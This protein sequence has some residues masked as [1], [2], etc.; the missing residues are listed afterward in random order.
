LVF[1]N[2]GTNLI[3]S[4]GGC[5]I[6]TGPNIGYTGPAVPGAPTFTPYHFIGSIG[7]VP[8]VPSCTSPPRI[9]TVT[10]NQ[11]ISITTQPVNASACT[12]KV[13]SF[14]V[15]AAGTSPSYQ[16]QVST[17]AGNTFTNVSNGGV[18]AGATSATLTITAP[19]VSMSGYLY[20]CMV[21]GASPCASVPSAQRLLTVNPLPT[22]TI[23]ASPY[24]K[25][26]PGLKTS[27]FSTVTPA[28]ASYTWL[29]NGGTVAGGNA[30]SLIVDVDGLGTYT[31]RVTDINGCTN[32]S[33]AVTLSDSVSGK[34]F[35]YPNPNNGQFQVRYYSIINNS[36]LPRGINV[37]DATGKRVLTNTYS[38]GS[39]YARMDVDLRN[40]GTGVY[41]IEVVD[42]NGNRLA[43]GRAEVLR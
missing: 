13:T 28:A 5:D 19:P 14:T 15:A 38:I 31:L 36:G 16:W 24:Q 25:L 35:I 37:Y 8:N 21:S 20:R 7:V 34:V 27:I 29:R 18:Y 4:A 42:V 43:L 30:S 11:P 32:T 33:N 17:D 40:H 6:L 9:V 12:D 3:A 1:S 26:F 2:T 39:P 23:A 22:V 10:V 41:W